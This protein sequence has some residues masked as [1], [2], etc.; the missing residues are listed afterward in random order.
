MDG[1]EL[2]QR[3]RALDPAARIVAVT[4]D[5]QAATRTQVFSIGASAY[6]TKVDQAAELLRVVEE[7]AA[8]PPPPVLT[9]AQ[10]DALT[11]LMNIAMGQAAHALSSL[12]EHR[13]ILQ[14]PHIEIL[15]AAGLRI[16]CEDEIHQV[17]AV[18]Q[19]FVSG[20]IS[21]FAALI[22]PYDHTVNLIR[23]LLASDS[24][25][26]HLTPAAQPILSEVG[27]I[28]LNA[29]VAHIGDQFQTRLRLSQAQTM[30]DQSGGAVADH[31]LRT[32]PTA[33]HAIVFLSRMRVS[34]VELLAY[35]TLLFPD[36]TVR[37][38]IAS[39]EAQG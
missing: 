19:Q 18:V 26:N 13:V 20:E 39:L 6:V 1:I 8:K 34:D 15:S 37:R 29:T 32:V 9:P 21:G 25:M 4:A 36:A 31:L 24:A 33:N 2:T 5:I 11:E 7:V 28:V 16:F 30:L 22:L 23:L 35:V 10:R 3:L 27:N 38:L 12:V 14:V 17:G